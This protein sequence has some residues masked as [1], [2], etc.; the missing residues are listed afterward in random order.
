MG[1]R[2]KIGLMLEE[3]R[4]DTLGLSEKVEG[5]GKDEFSGC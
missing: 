2:G 4:L 1:K 5:G 3:C